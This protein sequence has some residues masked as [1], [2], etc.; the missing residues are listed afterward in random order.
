MNTLK[1]GSSG[2][3]VLQLQKLL[4]QNGANLVADGSFG[5]L[6]DAAVKAFQASKSLV[7]DGVVGAKTWSAL[8]ANNPH[9]IMGVDVSHYETSFDFVKG[10]ADGVVFMMTKASEGTGLDKTCA[11]EC[12][13]AHDAGIKYKGVYHFHHAN[14]DVGVQ[15]K[16]Y[17]GQYKSVTSEMPPIL[18]LEETSVNGKTY[19]KVKDSALLWLESVEQQVGRVPI[20]YID[21]NMV[22]LLE[23][24]SDT[25]FN[26]YPRWVARYS[27]NEPTVAWTFWQFTDKGEQGA[28]TDWFHGSE[29]DLAAFCVAPPRSTIIDQIKPA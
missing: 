5:A 27:V 6:T 2:T 21:M 26:K 22:N 7:A 1:L 9:Y 28:D 29:A 10:K 18:D 25:R 13:K 12:Q 14:V 17:L 20:L 8:G 16:A 23:I 4:N 24:N 19:A 3:D 15:V 11:S